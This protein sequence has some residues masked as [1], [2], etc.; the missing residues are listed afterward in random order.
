MRAPPARAT[1][2]AGTWRRTRASGRLD[3]RG[4]E[5]TITGRALTLTE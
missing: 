5:I 1:M 2:Q 3:G 4:P